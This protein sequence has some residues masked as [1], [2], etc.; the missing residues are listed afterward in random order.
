MTIYPLMGIRRKAKIAEL[1]DRWKVRGKMLR[2]W[3]ALKAQ[4]L[5]LEAYLRVHPVEHL[6]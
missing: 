2:G 1:L 5:P 3:S 4:R 6:H